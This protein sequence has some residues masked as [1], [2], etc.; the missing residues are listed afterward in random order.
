MHRPPH[1]QLH[2]N[3]E[4]QNSH[5]TLYSKWLQ[6]NSFKGVYLCE[7]MCVYLVTTLIEEVRL[8]GE[9]IRSG[10]LQLSAI[11]LHGACSEQVFLLCSANRDGVSGAPAIVVPEL[12]SG[13]GFLL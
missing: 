11:F 12:G 6:Y 8:K 4:T 3:E 10:P 13:R 1:K 5:L 2:A 7:Y 9:W